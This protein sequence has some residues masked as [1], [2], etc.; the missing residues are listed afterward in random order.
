[1]GEEEGREPRSFDHTRTVVNVL[2][3]ASAVHAKPLEAMFRERGSPGGRYLGGMAA[4]LAVPYV[5]LFVGLSRLPDPL[6]ITPAF[7]GFYLLCLLVH[8]IGRARRRGRGEVTHRYFIG[9]PA[10]F[11]PRFGLR[12]GEPLLAA[13]LGGLLAP[14]S[15]A[16][17]LYFL[18]GGGCLFINHAVL[19]SRDQAVIDDQRDAELD[20]GYYAERRQEQP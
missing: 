6:G 8:T 15:P 20:A 5:P 2:L 4:A 19:E 10:Y 14:L 11:P 9:D 3:Y 13:V 12:V 16:L 18:V 7:V 17:G 1:M